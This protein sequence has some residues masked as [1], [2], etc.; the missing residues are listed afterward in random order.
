MA[1]SSRLL[2]PNIW[3]SSTDSAQ[4]ATCTQ[5]G[6]AVWWHDEAALDF[7]ASGLRLW[8]CRT[9]CV[10]PGGVEHLKQNGRR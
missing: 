3:L 7:A 9:C 5:C 6:Y 2:F 10:P 1:E 4:G 8:H